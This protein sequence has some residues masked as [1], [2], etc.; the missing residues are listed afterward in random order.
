MSALLDLFCYPTSG[1]FIFL[2]EE[3][4]SS[5]KTLIVWPIAF[6]LWL[7]AQSPRTNASELENSQSARARNFY[8]HF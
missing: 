6:A 1:R 3:P 7:F 5:T 4:N 8:T 2:I